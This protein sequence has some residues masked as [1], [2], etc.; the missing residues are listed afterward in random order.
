MKERASLGEETLKVL[1][2][3][4]EFVQ[5]NDGAHNLIVSPEIG[6]PICDAYNPFK[7]RKTNKQL[8][9]AQLA[10]KKKEEEEL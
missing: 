1:R 6:N 3:S 9:A 7:T 4:K 10:A 8:A 5:C 2:L